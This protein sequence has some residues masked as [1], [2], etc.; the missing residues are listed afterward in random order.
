MSESSPSTAAAGL[1]IEPARPEDASVL[2][3]MIREL[4]AFERLEDACGMD[5]DTARNHLTGCDRRAEAVIAWLEG[6]PA[7][8]AVYY[9]TYSTF[10]ARPGIHLE[11][12]FVRETHRRK[13]IGKGLLYYVGSIARYSGSGRFEWTTLHWNHDAR[14]LYS[15]IGARE[16]SD[17]RLLRMEGDSLDEFCRGDRATGGDGCRCGGKGA[18]HACRT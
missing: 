17:W 2:A 3:T 7:G 1:R 11:D 9:R 15:K 16:M 18:G 6:E 10:A 13:G 4:A 12:L 14:A 5:V 8:F